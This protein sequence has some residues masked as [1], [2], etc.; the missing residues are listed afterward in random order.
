MQITSVI[1]QM[2]Q[3]VMQRYFLRPTFA[4]SVLV[5]LL[6]AQH[7]I[8]NFTLISFHIA[9]SYFM[10]FAVCISYDIF[11]CRPDFFQHNFNFKLQYVLQIPWKPRRIRSVL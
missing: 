10:Y 8:V 5:A 7:K 2:Y 9:F 3:C 11:L 6:T 4:E 1:P